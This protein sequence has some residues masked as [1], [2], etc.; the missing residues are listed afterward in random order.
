MKW[1]STP[2]LSPPRGARVVKEM[3][4]QVSGYFSSSIR[5]RVVLP[6]PLG[7]AKATSCF[8]NR[9]LLLICFLS[10]QI[11]YL[12]ADLLERE[13][14]LHYMV[15]HQSLVALRPDRVHFPTQLLG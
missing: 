3:E 7:A 12:L 13:L 5:Q 15:G 1:Y 2:F 14:H 6:P 8:R 11:L 9:F 10:F 4:R